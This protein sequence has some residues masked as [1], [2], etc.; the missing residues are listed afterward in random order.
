[1]AYGQID[2]GKFGYWTVFVAGAGFLTDAY[3]VSLVLER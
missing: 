2:K 1:M 3:D